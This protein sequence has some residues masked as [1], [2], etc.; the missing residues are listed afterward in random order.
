MGQ[1]LKF[2]EAVGRSLK[3]PESKNPKYIFPVGLFWKEPESR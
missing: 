1:P 3:F 2:F